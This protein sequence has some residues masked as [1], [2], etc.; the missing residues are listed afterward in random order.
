MLKFLYIGSKIDK[1][2]SGADQVNKRNQDLLKMIGDVT[3]VE[4]SNRHIDRVCFQVSSTVLQTISKE[5]STFKYD[6]VFVQQSLLGRACLFIKSRFPTIKVITFFH[7]VEV[8]YAEE[9]KK[10]VGSIKALPFYWLVKYWEKKAVLNS[11]YAITLNKRDSTILQNYYNVTVSSELPTSFPDKFYGSQD[12]ADTQ[13]V[14]DYLFVGVAFFANIQGVQWFI[15]NVMP[16]VSGTLCIIGKGMDA[17]N[18]S[19]LNDR[20]EVIGFVDDLSEYYC[21]SRFVV[22]P[23]FYGAGMKTKTAEALMYGKTVIGTKEAL[24][25]YIRDDRCMIECNSAADFIEAI[26]NTSPS[27]LN[28]YS[29]KLFLE[30]Y[31]YRQSLEI[32]NKVLK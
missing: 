24:E 8:H 4:L 21:R 11:D 22:S 23:I 5:L 1:P 3:Y 27:V 32:L 16:F 26:N 30:H 9:Y 7:N 29:R 19:N 28:P 6:Y 15:D 12:Q 17:V 31:S 20:I 10:V 2:K 13:D 25:G 14:I 18:F